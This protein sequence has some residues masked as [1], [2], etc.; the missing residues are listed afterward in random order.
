MLQ[1]SHAGAAANV[2]DAEFVKAVLHGLAQAKKTLPCR[3]FYDARGSDLF[4]LITELPEYYLTRSEAA[5]S[6]GNASAIMGQLTPDHAIVELGAGSSRKMDALLPLVPA[7]N[8]FDPID[9]SQHA[10]TVA[11]TRFY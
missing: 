6:V 9:V 1:T 8:T 11:H 7:A 2:I 4:E 3:Y 10:R 5:L